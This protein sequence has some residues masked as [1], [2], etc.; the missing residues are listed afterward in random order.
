[1]DNTFERI[2]SSE[3]SEESDDSSGDEIQKI[4]YNDKFM[5]Q[6]KKSEYEK[7]RNKLFTKELVR[8]SIMI[9]SHNYFQPSGFDTSNYRVDFDFENSSGN[10]TVTTNYDVYKNVI[11][12]RL[13]STTIRTPPFNI[14]ET[15]NV[16]IW[17][18]G[19]SNVNDFHSSGTSLSG[20]PRLRKVVIQPGVYNM[21]ELGAVFQRYQDSF[22][23]LAGSTIK[24][25]INA[26]PPAQ[27]SRYFIQADGKDDVWE[28]IDGLP[29]A[30]NDP[31]GYDPTNHLSYLGP[32]TYSSSTGKFTPKHNSLQVLFIDPNE[33]NVTL[34]LLPNNGALGVTV[35]QITL[36]E[37]F[38]SMAYAIILVDTS[39]GGDASIAATF[40]WD[41][42]NITRAAA[43][44]FGFIP[45]QRTT[46]SNGGHKSLISNRAPDVS[47]HYVDLVIPE[48]P[49]IAC[50]RNSFGRD[51]VERVQLS[52]GH[53]QY[54]HFHPSKDE[55]I[56]QNYFNPRKLHRLTIQLY[57]PNNELYD[58]R[59]S[60]NSFEFEITMVSDKKLLH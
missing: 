16:I 21:R 41:Y 56:I 26:N 32:G 36:N 37:D 9:D 55:S 15:N 46:N 6:Q 13:L 59:N 34:E 17:S 43:R 38:K 19:G 11:G 27:Y 8:K 7:N 57:A 1:M 31:P 25:D 35:P 33:D 42:N 12:F 44:C 20:Q 51:I 4:I 58:T 10:S 60:D 48:I 28:S 3:E 54:L 40:Y 2:S 18:L 30:D 14:N 52:A 22:R 45:A 39:G 50:K 23:G 5:N 24:W 29:D 47:Q 53:G 49:S